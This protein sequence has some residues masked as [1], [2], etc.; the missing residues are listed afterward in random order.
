M[1]SDDK[2]SSPNS[3]VNSVFCESP[4]LDAESC[5]EDREGAA[6]VRSQADERRGGAAEPGC[7]VSA[8]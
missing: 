4:T 7:A 2:S 5:V 1:L 6:R 3:F 8:N